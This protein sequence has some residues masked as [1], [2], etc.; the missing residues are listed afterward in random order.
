MLMRVGERSKIDGYNNQNEFNTHKI[1]KRISSVEDM[2][3]L[4]INLRST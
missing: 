1:F 2:I 3:R 4:Y